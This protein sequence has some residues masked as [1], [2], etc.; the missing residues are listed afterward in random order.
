M[1]VVVWCLGVGVLCLSSEDLKLIEHDIYGSC[2]FL[3][4]FPRI[5]D[6]G[7]HGNHKALSLFIRTWVGT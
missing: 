4:L 3:H 5:S 2:E 6:L 1:Y 7:T